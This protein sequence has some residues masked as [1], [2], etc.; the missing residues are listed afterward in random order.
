MCRVALLVDVLCELGCVL[1]V[2]AKRVRVDTDVVTGIGDIAQERAVGEPA[3]VEVVE[4]LVA[5]RDTTSEQVFDT[6]ARGHH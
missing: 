3:V 2:V 4:F 5:L 1:I 6:I